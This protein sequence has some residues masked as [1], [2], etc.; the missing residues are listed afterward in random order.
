[1]P[2]EDNY[3]WKSAPPRVPG[4]SLVAYKTEKYAYPNRRASG[5]A[6]ISKDGVYISDNTVPVPTDTVMYRLT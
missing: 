5:W 2:L 1:M 4:L 6:Y 3:R